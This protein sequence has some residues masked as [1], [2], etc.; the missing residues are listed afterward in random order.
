MPLPDLRKRNYSNCNH[1]PSVMRKH[2]YG[3][4]GIN[5]R[6]ASRL[7]SEK[8]EPSVELERQITFRAYELIA[9]MLNT[10]EAG[11]RAAPGK[12]GSKPKLKSGKRSSRAT[13]APV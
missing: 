9:A 1:A 2:L 4:T 11:E 12:T 10:I 13:A 6:K 8:S 5:V 7:A 3:S